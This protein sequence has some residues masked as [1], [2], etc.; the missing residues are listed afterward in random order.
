[1]T[2]DGAAAKRPLLLHR[3]D[4][5]GSFS[6]LVIGL[7]SLLTFAGVAT[8]GVEAWH[9]L[10]QGYWHSIPVSAA[11][12]HMVAWT[13]RLPSASSSAQFSVWFLDLPLDRVLPALGLGLSTVS[14][15]ALR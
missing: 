5:A 13:P 7:G 2:R 15:F 4:N 10:A 1:M 9:W 12:G 8:L 6:W 3:T 14:I 11:V